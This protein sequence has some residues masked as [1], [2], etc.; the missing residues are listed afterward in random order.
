MPYDI[1][2]HG[3]QDDGG[4]QVGIDPISVQVDKSLFPVIGVLGA[5]IKDTQIARTIID[6]RVSVRLAVVDVVHHERIGC[7]RIAVEQLIIGSIRPI[8]NGD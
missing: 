6:R 7:K 5:H 2:C 8:S 3:P 4:P 1:P